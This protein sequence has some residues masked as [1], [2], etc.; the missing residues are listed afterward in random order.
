ML[1]HTTQIFVDAF[2]AHSKPI[3]AVVAFPLG[4][5]VGGVYTYSCLRHVHAHG[6][7]LTIV[8]PGNKP[9]DIIECIKCLGSSFPHTVILGYPP[10]IKTVI[11]LGNSLGIDWGA[12]NLRMVFAGEV[13]T[14]EWRSIMQTRAGIPHASYT[15][16][17]ASV[18][19]TSDAGVIACETP[20]SV[21]IRRW[22]SQHTHD[23]HILFGRDRLPSLLQY[24]PRVREFA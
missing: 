20:L 3:L 8:T 17:M 18:Y 12:Y 7:Q 4:L 13:F 16:I 9:E 6:V 2:E 22:F 23:A 10:F 11:D 19:G 14:E 1:L 15:R 5:W 21:C 24:D